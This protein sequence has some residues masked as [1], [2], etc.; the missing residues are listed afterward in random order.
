MT[1]SPFADP[2]ESTGLDYPQLAGSLLMVEV[3]SHEDHIPTVH[4]A[5]GE[6]N[7][8]IRA[9]VT[10]LDGPLAGTIFDDALIFPKV[11]IGQLRSR[12]GKIVLG[13]LF[14][15]EAHPGKNA[16]WK[17]APANDQDRALA[18]RALAV[19]RGN[20]NGGQQ[21]QH[22]A[23][24]QNVPPPQQQSIPSSSGWGNPAPA[25]SGGGGGQWGN[26]APTQEPPF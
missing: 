8:A 13:R 7:P 21:P 18:E 6:K 10:A 24:P 22:A 17:L 15:G 5:P 14:Q 19:I 4:T 11:L 23:P 1:N 2:A 25:Q 3:F 20:E 26:P 9:T 12:V 16:P